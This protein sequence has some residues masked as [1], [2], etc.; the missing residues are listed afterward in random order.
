MK[1]FFLLAGQALCLFSLWVLARRDWVRLTRPSL[2]VMGVVTAYRSTWDEGA[3]AY[4]PVF[5]FAGEEG[6]HEVV[7]AVYSG[8]MKPPV[9]AEVALRYPA[10]RPDLAQVPRPLMWA[11]VYALLG[12]LEALLFAVMMGWL[13]D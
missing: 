11:A 2:R 13:T 6:T 8:A 4:A 5:R 1:L 3:R 7:D 9:G 10:G 12:G